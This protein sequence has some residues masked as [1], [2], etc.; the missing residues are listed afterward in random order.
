MWWNQRRKRNLEADQKPGGHKTLV[1]YEKHTMIN[2]KP[3]KDKNRK[4]HH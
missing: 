3:D 1:R 4:R 2:S